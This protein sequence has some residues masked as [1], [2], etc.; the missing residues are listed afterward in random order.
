MPWS[1]L[2]AWLNS[3][4]GLLIYHI[5]FQQA[6]MPLQWRS[7][8]AL[9]LWSRS[10][11]GQGHPAR[12]KSAPALLELFNGRHCAIMPVF[13]FFFSWS[14]VFYLQHSLSL[15]SYIT[16]IRRESG[17]PF[18]LARLHFPSQ[19]PPSGGI[20][21]ER[22]R[23]QSEPTSDEPRPM[24]AALS[25]TS[26]WSEPIRSQRVTAFWPFYPM[27]VGGSDVRGSAYNQHIIGGAVIF[28]PYFVS[29]GP[30]VAEAGFFFSA[31]GGG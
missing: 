27:A 15:L 19:P 16:Q 10:G 2:H 30:F 6:L 14:F 8:I 3:K 28:I 4:C 25:F 21:T 17:P 23:S 5:M 18:L 7:M 29:L 26:R 24:S 20:C 12:H 1:N 9:V 11:G 31:P 13:C 22:A